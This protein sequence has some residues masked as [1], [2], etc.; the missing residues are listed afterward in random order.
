M[1]VR[2]FYDFINARGE[3]VIESW[4]LNDIPKDARAEIEVQLFLLRNVQTLQRPAAGDMKGR[5]C[6]GLIEI[7]VR[8][9]RQQYR[10]L[11]YY[12]PQRGQVTLLIGAR[13]KGN[14]LE[15]REACSIARRR[16]SDIQEGRGT[17]REHG[18]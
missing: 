6:R 13:E 9:N 1:A 11:A 3:N 15:P 5:E 16:I 12:G 4:L 8:H 2:T 18:L 7:R 14:K 10:L 17:I